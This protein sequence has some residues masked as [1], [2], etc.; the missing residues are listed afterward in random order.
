MRLWTRTIL[1]LLVAAGCVVAAAGVLAAGA[2]AAVP[3]LAVSGNRLIDTASG[4][5][6]VPRGVNWPSFEYACFH[7]YG[8]SNTAGPASVGPT[9][10]QAALIASWH[11]N[12]VRVPL[13]Q[14]CWLGD[15]GAPGGPGLTAQGY[16]DAVAS[17]VG[18]LHGAGL[19]VIL[20]L[21]WSGPLGLPADGQR[22]M[23]DDRSPAFWS[24]V[25]ATFKGDRGVLFDAFNEPYSRDA[26]TLTWPCWRDGGCQ[27]MARNDGDADDGRR[28]TITGM[29]ALVAAIRAAGA[30]QPILLGGLDYANDLRGWLDAKPVDGQL[31]ASFH[32]YGGQ[33]CHTA[34]CWDAEIAPVA[35]QV[36]VVTG[37]FGETDCT[38]THVT[39]YMNWADAR[40]IGYLAWQW[41]VLAPDE[42]ADPPCASLRLIEGPSG[43]PAAP[44]GTALKAHLAALAAGTPP[45]GGP[46][47]GT[48][49]P[50][51]PGS[52][53]RT[54]ARRG[55]DRTA[56]KLTKTS[57]TRRRGALVL[58][59][60]LNEPATV[61]ATLQ[62][63]IGRR[64]R[65]VLVLRRHAKRGAV[66][67]VVTRR[68]LRAGRYRLVVAVTDAAG[69]R[70]RSRTLGFRVG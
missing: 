56:P 68:A 44:N 31:V 23:A 41:V 51:A 66:R 35:A 10:E 45:P 46:G 14:D 39:N 32:N 8:Y 69:N 48:P 26:L 37:E 70:A 62:R 67:L 57:V 6:F 18:L 21:H 43:T 49:A 2:Q 55:G 24:S 15:D 52:A 11:A 36:P 1:A 54:P 7:G 65:R 20:D 63:R 33:R 34:A 47:S 9:A 19:A 3:S 50:P 40:G 5:T 12:V 30:P 4:A 38:D 64:T 42:L 13:N 61:R 17:W 22:M 16:R 25:A 58:A 60:T 53:R 29:S 27:A 59:L 28:F